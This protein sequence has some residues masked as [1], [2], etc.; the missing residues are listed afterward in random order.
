MRQKIIFGIGLLFFWWIMLWLIQRPEKEQVPFNSDRWAADLQDRYTMT[1]DLIRSKRLLGKDTA[2]IKALLGEPKY[3][4]S[5]PT[6]IYHAGSAAE[7]FGV[8]FYDLVL[9]MKD[10]RIDSAWQDVIRD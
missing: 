6:F 4:G 2:E 8:A 9:R 1:G 7:G 5:N 3:R 10:G